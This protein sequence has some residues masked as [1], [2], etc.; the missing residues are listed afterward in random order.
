[1]DGATRDER[2]AIIGHGPMIRWQSSTQL[3]YSGAEFADLFRHTSEWSVVSHVVVD[4]VS[5]VES[6]DELTGTLDYSLEVRLDLKTGGP[7]E[8]NRLAAFIGDRLE[9]A[10][11]IA[12]RRDHLSCRFDARRRAASP[13]Q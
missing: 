10:W 5:V 1:V 8:L 12:V 9:P 11:T 13:L 7:R 4:V 2:T 3:S 6:V